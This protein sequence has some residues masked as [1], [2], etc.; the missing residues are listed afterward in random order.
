[1]IPRDSWRNKPL[2]PDQIFSAGYRDGMN[3]RAPHPQFQTNVHYLKG[4]AEGCRSI[5]DP[6]TFVAFLQST[7]LTAALQSIQLWERDQE[8]LGMG[9]VALSY[10]NGY[11]TVLV[12]QDLHDLALPF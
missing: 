9:K 7:S 11:W 3:G 6:P 2:A 12:T 10:R 8:R 5:P 4:Y 1:M